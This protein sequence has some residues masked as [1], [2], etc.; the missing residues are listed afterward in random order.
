MFLPHF[1]IIYVL[2][3]LLNMNYGILYCEETKNLC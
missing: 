1:D 2:H 3:V